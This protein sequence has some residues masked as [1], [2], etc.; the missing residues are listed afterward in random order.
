MNTREAGLPITESANF[1]HSTFFALLRCRPPVFAR[2][3]IE[4]VSPFWSNLDALS[5]NKVH[6]SV[7]CRIKLL[8]WDAGQRAIC[9]RPSADVFAR[10]LSSGGTLEDVTSHKHDYRR[11]P[12]NITS[13]VKMFMTCTRSKSLRL[14]LTELVKGSQE[15]EEEDSIGLLR[16]SRENQPTSPEEITRC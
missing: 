7:D 4:H 12:P 3:H 2:S 14:M 15:D 6:T 1:S 13:V 8:R 5:S 10:F 16:R 11:F 9:Q